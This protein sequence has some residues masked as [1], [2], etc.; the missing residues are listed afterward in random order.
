MSGR[1]ELYFYWRA[2]G[3][4]RQAL[5]ATRR[6]QQAFVARRP[7]VAPRLLLRSDG[8][9]LMEVYAG[10]DEAAQQALVIE[11]DAATAPWR[12]GARHLEAFD[13]V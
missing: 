10:V 5:E 7:G 2:C 9:T 12:A 13:P 4:A 8:S 3:D 1:Q 6:F 11:G